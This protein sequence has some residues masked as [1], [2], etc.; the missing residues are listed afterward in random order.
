MTRVQEFTPVVADFEKVMMRSSAPFDALSA[1][2]DTGF[3]V[4][5]IP[6]FKRVVNRI[7]FDQ[8]HLYP[9]ARH[10]LL[11][12]RILKQIAWT[13]SGTKIFSHAS[14][15][16]RSVQKRALF[17]AALL[18]DIGKGDPS[19]RAF[20]KRRPHGEAHPAAKGPFGGRY[21]AV[22]FL[23][24]EHLLLFEIATR[25]TSTT[26]RRAVRGQDGSASPSG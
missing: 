19:Q 23:V 8:Y 26:R 3:L 20:R 7:Q 5:F 2:L 12:V 24:Q 22:V 9:V 11:T 16:R 1:M 4:R 6:E 10:L 15:T 25:G 13:R 17:W 18:H 21:R 14:S